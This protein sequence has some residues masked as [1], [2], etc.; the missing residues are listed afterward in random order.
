[1]ERS[2]GR[3]AVRLHLLHRAAEGE[4]SGLSVS[5]ELGRHG[6]RI[7]PGTLYPLLH[8]L[9]A[10]GLLAS[11]E[12]TENSRILRYYAA[13]EAGRA[14]LAT[15]AG[16]WPNSP[17]ICCLHRSR[18]P[19]PHRERGEPDDQATGTD[20]AASSNPCTERPR[21][22]EQG[23]GQHPTS[24]R[25]IE[26]S[27]PRE[28]AFLAGRVRRA[29]SC[30]SRLIEVDYDRAGGVG[31]T[32]GGV[33]ITTGGVV[34]MTGGVGIT[35]GGV[36]ITTGGVVGM[37]GGVGI[38]TGGVV[39]MTGGVGITTGGVVGMT[40]GLG[41]G[42]AG[43]VDT[44]VRGCRAAAVGPVAGEAED[45]A[46]NR[47]GAENGGAEMGAAA[48]RCPAAGCNELIPPSLRARV[49]SHPSYVQT[50]PTR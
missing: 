20:T 42:V 46:D 47:D 5:E 45:W 35:T 33:G 31:I 36:G 43:A 7:S 48:V 15:P 14:T 2:S 44:A 8:G 39:G 21:L 13:T 40:G 6:Y 18:P 29:V 3:A 26:S 34:G 16:R 1:V 17:P 23:T 9:E 24:Q 38:T 10:E 19:P 22:P 25:E 41:V 11:A 27:G 50:A 49:G 4:A 37:T 28:V 32:T 30:R 12:R